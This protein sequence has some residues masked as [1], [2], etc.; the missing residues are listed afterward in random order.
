MTPSPVGMRCPECAG[1][2]TAVRSGA[3]AFQDASVPYA[4]Y[5]LIALNVAAF[6]AE[7]GSGGL[8]ST[9]GG[10]KMIHDY[11]ING[12][13]VAGGDWFR[14]VTGGFLHAGM[15]HLLFNMFA[16]Y[17]LGTLLEPAIG[18]VRFVAIYLAALFGGS[19]GAILLDPGATTVGASGAIFGLFAATFLVA[20]GR[21]LQGVASQIGF[22]LLINL[23]L[24]LSVPGISVG[25]H[26][27]G[28]AVGSIAGLIIVAAERGGGARRH[29]GIELVLIA[30]LAA[31]A[32]AVALV[33][34]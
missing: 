16:L 19:A 5:V 17:V 15:L 3:A 31:A 7:L 22:W 10:G 23:V 1:Q 13:A 18:T 26:L 12:P 33:L 24:T 20:R 32:F 21:G 30:A 2:R 27:G 34:A 6:L 4:T 11:G 8:S 25:G 14:V 28:L 9:S 29:V